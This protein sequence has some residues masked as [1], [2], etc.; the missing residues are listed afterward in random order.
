[1]I[2]TKK[3]FI[4]IMVFLTLTTPVFIF[5]A[6]PPANLGLVPC[7]GVNCDFN[8]FLKLINTVIKFI[9][10]DLAIPIAAIMMFYAGFLLVKAQGGEA[11][12]KA[13]D[14]FFNAVWGLILAAGAFL[15][16]KTFLLILG[17]K[18]DWIGF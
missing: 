4:F 14:I 3:F 13:K 16:V 7:D 9:L 8:A 6:D 12:T 5:A 10:Y 18:G 17:Y 11:K 15:I 2:K 1:M